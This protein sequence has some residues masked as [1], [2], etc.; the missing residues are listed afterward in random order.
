MTRRCE[1]HSTLVQAKRPSIYILVTNAEIN[2]NF[3]AAFE[4]RC[5]EE[6]SDIKHYQVIGLDELESWLTMEPELGQLYFPTVFG[7][8]KFHLRLRIDRMYT[9]ID[10]ALQ[11]RLYVPS[12]E[13]DLREIVAVSNHVTEYYRVAVANVGTA[14]SY[15]DHTSIRLIVDGHSKRGRLINNPTDTL[16]GPI[17][18]SVNL[19]FAQILSEFGC[20]CQQSPTACEQT[21]W[22]RGYCQQKAV[23]A[24]ESMVVTGQY[25]AWH[26]VLP[27]TQPAALS[28]CS[29]V[30][31]TNATCS[32]RGALEL[33]SNLRER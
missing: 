24:A 22:C 16:L 30:S 4:T 1:L 19:S 18:S 15:I 29:S 6:N 23:M 25:V 13:I 17:N 21:A 11:G 8:P 2:A 32:V 12:E 3:R 9:W 7:G 5:R 28:I 20:W 31:A 33:T 10:A 27:S 26:S 14:T